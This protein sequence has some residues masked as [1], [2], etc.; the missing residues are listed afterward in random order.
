M[1]S[2]KEDINFDKVLEN[3]FLNELYNAKGYLNTINHSNDFDLD[4]LILIN[5]HEHKINASLDFEFICN[6]VNILI[7]F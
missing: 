6:L 4:I 7:Q 5:K 3:P 2:K 1:V